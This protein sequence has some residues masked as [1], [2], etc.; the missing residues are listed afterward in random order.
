MLKH[1]N[2]MPA[3]QGSALDGA[4][5]GSSQARR[6]RVLAA[7]VPV[8][9]TLAALAGVGTGLCFTMLPL[10]ALSCAGVALLALLLTFYGTFLRRRMMRRA[11]ALLQ[12]FATE[13]REP[14]SLRDAQGRF[15]FATRPAA[16]MLGAEPVDLLGYCEGDFLDPEAVAGRAAETAAL[17]AEPGRLTLRR[18]G[19][20]PEGRM[21][22][23]LVSKL[24]LALP[25]RR[26]FG[27]LEV[28]REVGGERAWRQFQEQRDSEWRALFEDHPL[29][30]L[31]MAQDGA[32]LAVNAAA[33][34]FYGYA[35]ED[36]LA[37]GANAIAVE[38]GNDPALSLLRGPSHRRRDGRRMP[39]QVTSSPL[40]YARRDARLLLIRPR[41]GA[42]SEGELYERRYRDLIDSG[43]WLVWSQDRDGRVLQANGAVAGALGVDSGELAGQLITDFM[44]PEDH[45]AALAML[46]RS[47]SRRRDTGVISVRGRGGERRIWQY[48][49]LAYPEDTPP[50]VL[51]VAQDIT[52]RQNYDRQLRERTMVDPLTGVYNR[53]YLDEF[54]TRGAGDQSFGCIVV[55]VVAF[56]RFNDTYGHAQGDVMLRKLAQFL[57]AACRS[58]DAVVRLGGDEF[59]L[60]LPDTSEAVL[61]EIS[62]R[63]EARSEGELGFSISAG[64]ALRQDDEGFEATMKRAD[65]DL[66]A[67]RAIERNG[68]QHESSR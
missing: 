32:L 23:Y 51:L 33:E 4:V 30:A 6:G 35:A 49:S 2:P 53:R 46:E 54:N 8:W 22:E 27:L 34:R 67:R 66:L 29:P 64:W 58:Q 9:A 7:G 60:V 44:E 14:I 26:P 59:V 52:L 39:V 11:E 24:A 38:P 1:A 13:L 31:V 43:I 63:L 36:L 15:L 40:L 3:P 47:V 12:A 41:E 20:D 19:P 16:A 61:R 25:R 62:R 68:R 42:A 50:Q 10:L 48:H 57:R 37:L 5:P 18:R 17:M 65:L 28:G 45:D 21:R 56:K 55:D